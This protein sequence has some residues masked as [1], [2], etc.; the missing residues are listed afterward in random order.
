MVNVT[1]PW[2]MLANVVDLRLSSVDKKTILGEK[3][4]RLCN[5]TNVYNH[6]VLRA[7]M[8]YMEATATAREIQKC[9]LEVGDVV[10][11]KDSETPDDIGV[12][13]VVREPVVNLVCGYHLAILRPLKSTLDGEYLHYALGTNNA[14]RQFRMY[15]N[16]ITR[17]GLR[18]ADIERVAI[19]RPTLPEQRKI[20]A[21]LSA[22][23][24]AIEKT[25]AVIDQV[26]VVK[27]GLMQE[28][29][30][31]G[32]PGRHTRFKQTEIGEIPEEWDA[33][34]LGNRAELQPGFPFK[35]R[36]FAA[37]GDR[38]LRGSNVGVGRLVWT[39]D[40]TEYFP[41]ARRA[42]VKDYELRDSDIVVAMDR[43][44]VSD[45]FKVSRVTAN[46]LPALLL[47]RVGRFRHYRG[48]T[49]GYLWQLLQSGY[50]QGHLQ[51]TQKGTDLPHI[52]KT[53]I[54]SAVCPLPPVDEQESIA[55]CLDTFDAYS[56]RLEQERRQAT[57]LKTGLMSVLLTGELCVNPAPET[58]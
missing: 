56:T 21:I 22:V 9:K 1:W 41:S 43:P 47:Q 46:D 40:K 38:L 6:S 27:R 54:E 3:A 32:L 24:D 17:F 13:A 2:D 50:V 48:L 7:D 33:A 29:L 11:T 4:V 51:I 58:A 30:T 12:P 36:D 8:D 23:D 53:E 25:R 34:P 55:R 20:A 35:S 26:Q 18:A 19:P 57:K 15:A 16:G 37:G 14:K 31:R 39:E 42:E 44:F 49:P 10:I 45:G 28:L 52:S 5:Y